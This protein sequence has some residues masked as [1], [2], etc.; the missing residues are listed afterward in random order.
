MYYCISICHG[1]VPVPLGISN[2][3]KDS[4]QI[5]HPFSHGMSDGL[6]GV[7]QQRGIGKHLEL[8]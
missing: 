4:L 6:E 2:V 5:L 8:Q 1:Y 7:M 3:G